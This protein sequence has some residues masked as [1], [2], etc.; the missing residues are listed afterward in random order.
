MLATALI[1]EEIPTERVY[2][3]NT[4]SV[5][6]VQSTDSLHQGSYLEYMDAYEYEIGHIP[7]LDRYES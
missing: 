6:K 1:S 2:F 7:G 4:V 3:E 5:E